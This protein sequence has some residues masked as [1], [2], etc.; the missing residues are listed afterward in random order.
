MFN[1]PKII[2]LLIISIISNA[3]T[4]NNNI[5]RNLNL[6][7]SLD[8]PNYLGQS[9]YSDIFKTFEEDLKPVVVVKDTEKHNVVPQKTEPNDYLILLDDQT[10]FS[11]FTNFNIT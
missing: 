8:G 7:F 11:Y 5:P 6:L 10:G 1:D 4:E 9:N 2:F 3:Q